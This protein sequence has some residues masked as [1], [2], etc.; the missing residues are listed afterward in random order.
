MTWT[1]LHQACENQSSLDVVKLARN[2][3]EE[4]FNVDENGSTPLHLLAWGQPSAIAV[5]IL[6]KACPQAA[7]H[8]DIMGNTPLHIA[9]SCASSDKHLVQMLL[10]ACPIAASMANHEGLL[11]LH[12][13]C[14]Y[15]PTN[16]GVIGLLIEAYPYAL[17]VHIKVRNKLFQCM[18]LL[19]LC[20]LFYSDG[21]P[22]Y[23]EDTTACWQGERPHNH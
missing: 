5:Q 2:A 10:D 12:M 6:I 4:G 16:K 20:L 7:S 11:P 15:S 1:K 21:I 18:R 23:V 19:M 9:A 3:P 13:A 22:S 8:Q 17:R 14:R